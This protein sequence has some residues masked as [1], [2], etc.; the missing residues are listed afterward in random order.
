VRNQLSLPWEDP[1]NEG[2]CRASI[3]RDLHRLWNVGQYMVEVR[4]VNDLIETWGLRMAKMS[5]RTETKVEQNRFYFVNC[6]VGEDT[7][8]AVAEAYPSAESTFDF[9]E[10]VLADGLKV[11]FAV[12]SRNDMTICSLSDRREESPSFGACLTGG[13]DGWYDALRVT[14]Y[15]YTALLHGDLGQEGEHKS[16][17]SRII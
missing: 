4:L 2:T 9:L 14:A 11:S 8:V 7:W 17:T 3:R 5:G 6:P 13:A 16:P 10:A 12:N 1:I 15:K